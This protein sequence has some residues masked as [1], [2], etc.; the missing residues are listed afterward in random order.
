MVHPSREVARV[1]ELHVFAHELRAAGE[2]YRMASAAPSSFDTTLVKL[3]LDDGTV[4]WGETCPVHPAYQPHHGR[5]ARA[6]LE[7]VAPALIGEAARPLPLRRAMGERLAGHDYAKAALEIALL[8]ALG[9]RLGVPLAELL[10]GKATDRVP[11]YYSVTVS[12]AGEAAR[13]AAE[14]AREGYGRLQV[15]VGRDVREAI[16]TVRRVCEAVGPGVRVAVDANRGWTRRDALLADAALADLP[17]VV[18]QPCDTL[19]ENASLR[20]RLRHPLYL[21][22]ATQGLDATLDI[23]ERDLADGLGL[24][25][26]RLGGPLAFATARDLCALR[27]LPHTCDDAW[28]GDV[29]AAACAQLAAT[30]DPGLL[31]AVWIAGPY[32]RAVEGLVGAVRVEG[33]RIAVPEGLGL[34]IAPEQ[35]VL[36]APVASW[37]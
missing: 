16:E 8:D 9:R 27:R 34:G 35:D 28:G 30:V 37:G 24:K 19:A 11:S 26:T 18:E 10:G 22:E 23:V 32:T 1:A 33:G 3:V 20:G 5:G 14:K 25:V 17:I 6:A 29:I 36:G 7:E 2:A 31:E 13:T 12:D 21:D 4:G 15:K